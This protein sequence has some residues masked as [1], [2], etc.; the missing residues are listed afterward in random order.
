VPVKSGDQTLIQKYRDNAS[1]NSLGISFIGY[2]V[3]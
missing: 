1:W 3:D 2:N